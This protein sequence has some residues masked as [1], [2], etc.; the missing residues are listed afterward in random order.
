MEEGLGAQASWAAGCM[1]CPASYAPSKQAHACF[2]FSS[3]L[4]PF[5]PVTTSLQ[6]RYFLPSSDSPPKGA[7]PPPPG[8]TQQ[9]PSPGP[10]VQAGQGQGQQEQAALQQAAVG[11]FV[12][13]VNQ[14]FQ[15][16]VAGRKEDPHFW[17]AWAHQLLGFG[18]R[19]HTAKVSVHMLSVQGG[20]VSYLK[21]HACDAGL[22]GHAWA[23]KQIAT[24]WART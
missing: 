15:P 20:G 9:D 6:D 14:Q 1:P 4:C 19:E 11:S 13:R 22:L 2:F 8:T 23:V 17:M 5:N 21:L 3:L 24:T 18:R 7:T 12:E 10:D 16:Q